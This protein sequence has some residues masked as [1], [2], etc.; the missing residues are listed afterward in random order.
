MQH[1][2]ELNTEPGGQW[3][4][5]LS[6]AITLFGTKTLFI[7]SHFLVEK[8]SCSHM[9]IKNIVLVSGSLSW[10]LQNLG[11][12]TLFVPINKG[13]RGTSVGIDQLL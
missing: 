2:N 7:S 9:N 5:Q 12:F 4:G 1:L 3:S 6:N 10:P 8:F 13:F 11:P